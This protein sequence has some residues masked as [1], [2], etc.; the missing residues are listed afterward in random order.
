MGRCRGFSPSGT[1][2]FESPEKYLSEQISDTPP[3]LYSLKLA[4]VYPCNTRRVNI[5]Q[6]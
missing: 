3:T 5:A 2:F 4:A 6:V 1:F